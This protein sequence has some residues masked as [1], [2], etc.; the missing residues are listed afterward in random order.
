[1][2]PILF[3]TEMVRA[4][5]EGRKTVTRRLVKSGKSTPMYHRRDKFYGIVD[6]LNNDYKNWYAGFYNDSDIFYGANGSR[7]ID[8]IYFKA[9]C[10][11]NDILYVRE[12]WI[13]K[14][15]EENGKLVKGFAYK[16]DFTGYESMFA[17]R[18]SIHMPK[19]AARIFLK[20]TDVRVERLQ[21][22]TEEQAKAEGVV[23]LFDNLSDAEYTDWSKR[24]GLYPKEKHE[25]SYLNYLWHG[26]FGKYGTGN[27]DSD[28][29][30]YQRSGYDTA[31]GSFS[32]LWE[33]TIKR[34]QRNI[35]GWEANP[36]V[37]VI[38]FERVDLDSLGGAYER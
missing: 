10:K 34:D 33:S 35:Y 16:A 20:V 3:N 25:W 8:A 27:A 21:D 22:I 36:Y 13:P 12:T 6:H 32:S 5:L 17:W 28:S 19:E 7:H 14:E 24:T 2:K 30:E 18:P 31:K 38:E 37:W 11:V 26:N 4:I 29:W 9:P 1:M 23:H 15:S